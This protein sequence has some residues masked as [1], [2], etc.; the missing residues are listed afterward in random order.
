MSAIA[1]LFSV[2]QKRVL[3]TGGSRG[4]GLMFAKGFAANGASVTISARSEETLVDAIKELNAVSPS[5]GGATHSYV[6]GDVSSRDGCKKLAEDVS[7]LHGGSIDVLINNAGAAWGEPFERVSGKANWGFDKV[8]DLNVKGPFYLTQACLP[9][10]KRPHGND[11]PGRVINVGSVVGMTPQDAPT[12]AYDASKAA[13]HH[14]TKK[15]SSEL[16]EHNITCNAIAPGFV[17]SKMSAQL[18]SYA[19]FEDIAAKTPMKRLGSDDDMAGGAIY[20]SSKAGAWVT[21]VIL[22]IDGGCIGGL[23]IP[24]ASEE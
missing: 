1:N 8:L 23:K 15:L 3:V 7:A 5:E 13:I 6:V 14:L 4:I 18:G 17:P 22:N 21:G 10:L 16:S 2:A 12:H 20:L 9:L 11:D 19:T 24:L